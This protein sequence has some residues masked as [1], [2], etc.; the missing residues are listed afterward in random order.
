MVFSSIIFLYLFLPVVFGVNLLL[1]LPCFFGSNLTRNKICNMWLIIAS[2]LFYSWGEGSYLFVMLFSSSLDYLAALVIAKAWRKGQLTSLSLGGQRDWSQ[3]VALF[4]SIIANLAILGFFKYYDFG[5]TNLNTIFDSMGFDAYVI[6]NVTKVALPLGISFYTFQSLSYTIDVYRGEAT[7]TRNY[8]DFICFVT[9]FPQL[10]AG[11]IVRYRDVA[12]ELAYRTI[13]SSD[14]AHG[15][16]RF[17]FGLAKKVL[18]ANQMGYVADQIF[19]IPN[20]EL[21]FGLSWLGVICYTFQIYYDFSGYSDMAIGM[22]LMFG[23]KFLENFNYPYVSRSVKEFWRRWHISLS[24]WFRDYLYIPLGG[25]RCSATRHYFNMIT[26][27]FL[28]GLWHGAAWNFVFWGMF[29]GIFLTIESVGLSKWLERQSVV[30]QRIYA[31][32][33]IMLGWVIFRANDMVQA[34]AFCKAMIGFGAGNS[35]MYYPEFYL[36]ADIVTVLILAMVCSHPLLPTLKSLVLSVSEQRGRNGRRCL[37][38]TWA[39]LRLVT[40]LATIFLASL[41]LSSG[42]YNPFIYFRF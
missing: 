5:I 30:L 28:C 18:I 42:T 13:N 22:G 36:R 39:S 19:A 7:A 38:L 37:R 1:N 20:S 41:F 21:T 35:K 17:C 16:V 9:L 24:T 40:M 14:I 32:L 11:P 10:V 29:H 4:L 6:K 33:V 12:H 25:N 27:F 31:M 23:F 2:I 26:V 34:G 15:I 8:F 3:K